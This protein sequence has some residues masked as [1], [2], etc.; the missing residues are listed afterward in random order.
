VG[1]LNGLKKSSKVVAYYRP[2]TDRLP[3]LTDT[4][5][6]WNPRKAA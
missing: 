5:L 6:D 3:N 1:C 4:A 2:C